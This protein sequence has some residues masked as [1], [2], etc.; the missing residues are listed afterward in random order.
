MDRDPNTWPG[1]AYR[2]LMGAWWPLVKALV[3]ISVLV[4][5]GVLAVVVIDGT[6]AL[7]PIELQR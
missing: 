7:G 6:L 2:I 1:L 3:M 4:A 5:L